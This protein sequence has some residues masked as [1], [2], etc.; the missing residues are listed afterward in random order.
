MECVHLKEVN[1][2]ANQA[3]GHGLYFFQDQ[4]RYISNVIDFVISGLERNEY[5]II[6]ENDRIT[7]LIIKRLT[8]LLNETV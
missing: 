3:K 5:S 7:P 4:E 1:E 8:V 6:I 2:I